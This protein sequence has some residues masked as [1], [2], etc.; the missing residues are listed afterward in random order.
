MT[1]TSRAPA[2]QGAGG[3]GARP[4]G[5]AVFDPIPGDADVLCRLRVVSEVTR[6]VSL[7]RRPP[8]EPNSFQ[9]LILHY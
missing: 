5:S 7:R 3:Q 1:R 8:V 4:R 9:N 6:G 2:I